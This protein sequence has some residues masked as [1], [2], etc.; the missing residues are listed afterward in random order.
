MNSEE[1]SVTLTMIT[2]P[3]QAN[4]FGTIHGGE[5]MRFMDT[6]A[7]CTAIKYAKKNCVTA[8][9]DEFR[10]LKPVHIGK[11]VTCKGVVVYTGE[12]SIEVHV[13]LDTEDIRDNQSKDRAIEAFFTYVAVDENGRPTSVPPYIPETDQEKELYEHVKTRRIFDR[14]RLEEARRRMA[15]KTN[16]DLQNGETAK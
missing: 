12:T 11:F 15:E 10:F 1:R 4:M 8:S 2:E 5:V 3:R 16:N 9:V 13:T 6:T 7:G 14:E